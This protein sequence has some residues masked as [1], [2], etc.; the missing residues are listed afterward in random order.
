[1]LNLDFHI[2]TL[3]RFKFRA[4]NKNGQY[5]DSEYS[6]HIKTAGIYI[7]LYITT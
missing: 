7:P 6:D 1:M 4:T 2:F 3:T 5:T